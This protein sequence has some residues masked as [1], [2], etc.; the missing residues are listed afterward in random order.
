MRITPKLWVTTCAILCV[1]VTGCLQVQHTELPVKHFRQWLP[2]DA[3]VNSDGTNPAAERKLPLRRIADAANLESEVPAIKAAAEI[4][5]QE[6]LKDQK[7]KALL[8]LSTIGCGCYDADGKITDALLAAL[9]DCTEEVRLTTVQTIRHVACQAPCSQCNTHSCCKK[10]IV[11]KLSEIAYEYNDD[12][13]PV[14]PS[15]R[16]R[17][18]AAEA[19]QVCCPNV[20]IPAHSHG[21]GP[22]PVEPAVPPMPEQAPPVEGPESSGASAQAEAVPS[23]TASVS[24]QTAPAIQ[25]SSLNV[26]EKASATTASVKAARNVVPPA[27]FP[28]IAEAAP[29]AAPPVT[30]AVVPVQE[31]PKTV[32]R[33]SARPSQLMGTISSVDL[34]SSTVQLRFTSPE[35]LNSGDRLIVYHRYEMGRVATVG[36]LHVASVEGN[37]VL[38]KPGDSGRLDRVTVGD[39]VVLVK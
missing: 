11:E 24:Q 17:Q 27:P 6:D 4:K 22:T 30:A 33:T 26:A 15:Q 1:S 2:K 36:D 35:H 7:V 29:V 23:V 16:V 12:G 21:E 31:A 3:R 5:Q 25:L 8:Y 38:A 32:A 10:A 13:C 39:S 34:E 14:E 20:G 28:A 9:D 37:T 18:A 19:L